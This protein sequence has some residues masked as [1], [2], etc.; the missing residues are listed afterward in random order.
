MSRSAKRTSTRQQCA[1]E[2]LVRFGR[3]RSLPVLGGRGGNLTAYFH[4]FGFGPAENGVSF[5]RY[6]TS[7]TNEHFV[8]QAAQTFGAANSLPKVGPVVIRKSCIIRPMWTAR[9]TRSTNT[10]NCT[11]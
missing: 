8:A 6:I 11:T 10:S 9:T 2:F 3:R 1:D 5:G 7:Q 4:G